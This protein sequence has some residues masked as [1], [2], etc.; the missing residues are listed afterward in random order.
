MHEEQ[1]IPIL[2]GYIVE[3]NP[4]GVSDFI[5]KWGSPNATSKAELQTK[6]LELL[7]DKSENEDLI[8]DFIKLHPDKSLIIEAYKSKKL[9]TCNTCDCVDCDGKH[10]FYEL[11]YFKYG[12]LLAIILLLIWLLIRNKD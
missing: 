11:S 3:T 1:N 10:Y 2:V 8:Y 9:S 4:N 5:V 12:V 7:A 6:C